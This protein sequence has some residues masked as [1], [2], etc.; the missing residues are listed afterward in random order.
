MAI[1]SIIKEYLCPLSLELPVEPVTAE[2]GRVYNRAHQSN[3]SHFRT[4]I[5]NVLKCDSLDWFTPLIKRAGILK[6]ANQDL[7]YVVS[8][9]FWI[10]LAF[11]MSNMHRNYVPHILV[12]I[13]FVRIFLLNINFPG[14]GVNR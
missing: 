2:D 4:K 5:P 10:P 13:F 9:H 3:E 8:V 7:R 11:R 14:L 1:D 6:K 12:G